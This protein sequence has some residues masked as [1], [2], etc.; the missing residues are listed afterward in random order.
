MLEKFKNIDFFNEV[1]VK[2]TGW[3]ISFIPSVLLTIVLL[4]VTLKL[5]KFFT[6]RIK[7]FIIKRSQ[8]NSEENT[9]EAEKRINTLMGII[10]TT[11]KISTWIIFSMILLREIGIDIGPILAGAGIVGIA[12]GFGSQELVKNIFSGFFILLDNRIRTGDTAEINGISGLVE[13]V[14]LR[15][16]TLR[17]ISGTVHIFENGKI[18]TLANKTK[19]WSATVLDIGVDYKEDVNSVIDIMRNIGDDMMNDPEQSEKILQPIEIFGLDRFEDSSVVIKAR[20]K[21]K[22]SKQWEVDREYKKRL[23]YKFDEKGITIP[24]PQSTISF[25]EKNFPLKMQ[26]EDFKKN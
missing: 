23:K 4:I 26:M 6:N 20:I 19:E 7:T 21:T 17:D 22:P 13:N 16:I 9:E 10:H 8:Q 5:L 2:G 12:V 14:E 1:L 18:N 15:T 24:F 25:D 3:I 11:G